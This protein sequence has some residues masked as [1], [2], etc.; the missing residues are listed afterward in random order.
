M[1][2]KRPPVVVTRA[3]QHKLHIVRYFNYDTGCGLDLSEPLGLFN[4]I[5]GKD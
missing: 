1:I 3:I 4:T 2:N 5:D